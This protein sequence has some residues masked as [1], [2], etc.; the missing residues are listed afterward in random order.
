MTRPIPHLADL[1]HPSFGCLAFLNALSIA[2]VCTTISR[3][4]TSNFFP[5]ASKYK[6]SELPDFPEIA[7][8]LGQA[9]E[10]SRRY[11]QRLTAHPNE[12]V[13]LAAE[14]PQLV[15][16]SLMDLEVHAQVRRVG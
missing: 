15:E 7:H 3:R 4:L 13:K 1:L 2:F 8:I 12:F 16:E 14:R 10:L 9:G 6:L 5:W 11:G